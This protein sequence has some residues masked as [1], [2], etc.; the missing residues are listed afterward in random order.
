MTPLEIFQCWQVCVYF[1][2]LLYM[3]W[4]L[5]KLQPEMT[6]ITVTMT[7]TAGQSNFTL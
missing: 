7:V 2:A 3:I 4:L 1:E 6:V 5:A